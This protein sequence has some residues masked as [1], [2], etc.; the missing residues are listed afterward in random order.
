MG[1]PVSPG[2]FLRGAGY[3]R[4]AFGLLLAPTLRRYVLGPLL[5][6]VALFGA[7]VYFGAREFAA[8][9]DQWVPAWLAWLEWLL[10]LLFA[11][12]GLTVVFFGFA[13]LANLTA[14][15]LNGR[16]A[17]AVERSLGLAPAPRPPEG[18]LAG[19]IGDLRSESR[20]VLFFAA[21]ALPLLLLYLVPL[22]QLLAP[23]L[24]FL[25]GAWALGLEYADF[26]LANRGLRFADQRRLLAGRLSTLLGFGSAMMLVTMVPVLNFLAVPVG[27]IGATLLCARELET[28][29]RPGESTSPPTG[30]AA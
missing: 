6:N 28:L 26:P 10:W 3:V 1:G 25:Y 9:V 30:P 8:L 12:V 27:V 5:V 19:L 2:G 11:A 17:E 29:R 14:A 24:W 4:Q 7:A 13:L 18:A 20:K 15:P 23:V 21:W 22:L 16:L